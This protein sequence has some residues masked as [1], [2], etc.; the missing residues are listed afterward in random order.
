MT[1]VAFGADDRLPF[2]RSTTTADEKAN[3]TSKRSATKLETGKRS[4]S[5]VLVHKGGIGHRGRRFLTR[6]RRLRGTQRDYS[7]HSGQPYHGFLRRRI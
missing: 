4:I 1:E 6:G 5:I 3:R 7:P 2:G